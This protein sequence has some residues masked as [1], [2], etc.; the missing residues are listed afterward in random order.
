MLY[1][2]RALTLKMAIL[3]KSFT[4]WQKMQ[5]EVNNVPHPHCLIIFFIRGGGRIINIV[6]RFFKILVTKNAGILR[7]L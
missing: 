5:P 2:L 3:I 7:I 4:V 6:Y 1:A